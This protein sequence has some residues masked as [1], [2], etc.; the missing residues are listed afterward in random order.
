MRFCAV[1]PPEREV[2]WTISVGYISFLV[3]VAML[4]PGFQHETVYVSMT[5]NTTASLFIATHWVLL[6]VDLCT[7]A[8]DGALIWFNR[9]NVNRQVLH[10]VSVSCTNRVLRIA[11]CNRMSSVR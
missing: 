6:A 5:T 1:R 4:D 7:S 10:E 9:Q 2:Q 3:C 8:V 11:N